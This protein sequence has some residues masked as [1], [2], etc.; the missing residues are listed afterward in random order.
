M[1]HRRVVDAE[2]EVKPVRQLLL[3]CGRITG[4]RGEASRSSAKEAPVEERTPNGFRNQP[5]TGH[6]ENLSLGSTP[7]P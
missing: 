1:V 3:D 7:S 4:L 2:S 5:L 6:P